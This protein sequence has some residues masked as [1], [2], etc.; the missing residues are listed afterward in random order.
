MFIY[1]RIM[2]LRSISIL[3][4]VLLGA[5]AA[6]ADWDVV[7]DVPTIDQLRA[8]DGSSAGAVFALGNYG[9][10]LYDDGTGWRDVSG[11]TERNLYGVWW[12][13]ADEAFAVG[14]KG[15]LLRYDGISWNLVDSGT[16]QR[17]RD[18]WSAAADDIFAVG[19]NG[20]LLHYDGSSWK[21]MASPT[22]LTL[23]SVWGA[24]GSDVYAVGGASGTGG[25]GSGV[26]IHYDGEVWK[27]MTE[28]VIPRLQ[29]VWGLPGGPIM[30]VGE[31]GTIFLY[32]A[33][34]NSWDSMPSD[35]TETLRD[36][37]GSSATDV[38]AVGDYG[39]ILH[40]DGTAWAFVDAGIT[41]RLFGIWGSSKDNIYAVGDE[42]L[43][44]H[45]TGESGDNGTNVCP[46]LAAVDNQH[47]IKL[48]RDLRDARLFSLQR[49]NVIARYY[50]HAHEVAA[51]LRQHPA[52]KQKLS[53]L[54]QASRATLTALVRGETAC[55]DQHLVDAVASFMEALQPYACPELR[56]AL[57]DVR[58]EI[59]KGQLLEEL[60]IAVE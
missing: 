29:D 39:T 34:T 5:S 7:P 42:G 26:I 25:V 56:R 6:R 32:N 27:T 49:M 35:T 45:Y 17:L 41:L 38:Y 20:T 24:S 14:D 58:E 60:G 30:A 9:A 52:L 54:V 22:P 59:K 46:F 47:D 28:F 19:E 50:E 51:I 40:F 21:A 23:Q 36:I 44:V 2:A 3:V 55:A 18:V 15:L 33:D 10:I 48:L 13:S 12:V 8:V 1:M 37:W 57:E 11:I 16:I 31:S 43:I 53:R 4:A